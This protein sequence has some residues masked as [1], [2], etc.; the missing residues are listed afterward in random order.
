MREG[1]LGCAIVVDEE[2][3]PVGVFN[4]AMLRTLMADTPAILSDKVESHMATTFPWVESTDAIEMVLNAME[5]KNA[6]FVVVVDE[7]GRVAGLTGQKG[8]ME[9]VAE[10][11]PGEV[12]VQRVGT[13]SFPDSREGA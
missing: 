5:E 13:E 3:H 6:R 4:E 7:E 9:Y 10:H 2:R 8:L 11:F 1:R 12:M